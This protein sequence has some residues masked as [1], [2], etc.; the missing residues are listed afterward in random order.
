[1]G[2]LH[3][4]G[5]RPDARSSRLRSHAD[6]ANSAAEAHWESEHGRFGQGVFS[7][8]MAMGIGQDGLSCLWSYQE[9]LGNDHI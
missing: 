9:W 4:Y 3:G 2:Q 6:A 5:H 8:A 1:M 7:M